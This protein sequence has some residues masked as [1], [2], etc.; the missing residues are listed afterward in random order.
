MKLKEFEEMF[1]KECEASLKYIVET[2]K[3]HNFDE[4]TMLLYGSGYLMGYLGTWLRNEKLVNVE[5]K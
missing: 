4:E 5:S 3:K 2:A 1:M